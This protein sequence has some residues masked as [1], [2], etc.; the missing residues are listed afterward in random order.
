[1]KHAMLTW[2]LGA[3]LTFSLGPR[4][5]TDDTDLFGYEARHN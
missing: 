5:S 1:M 3:S 2:D 4:I